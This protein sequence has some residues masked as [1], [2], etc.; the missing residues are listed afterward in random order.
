EPTEHSWRSHQV[1]FGDLAAKPQHLKLL[2]K[3]MRS[4][5]PEELFD[6][7]GKFRDEYAALAPKGSR[8]MGANPHA[9]GGLLLHPLRMPDFRD[10]AVEVKKPGTET[11]EATRIAGALLR[12]II[13]ENPGNF[14]I[15]GPDE[16]ASNRLNTVFEAT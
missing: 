16:T 6:E 7:N 2:E 3:W 11:A 14:R 15:V 4:Y 8:R 12:D 13:K 10:Y 9:N 5:E 1:P